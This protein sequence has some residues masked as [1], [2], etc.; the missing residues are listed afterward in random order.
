VRKGSRKVPPRGSGRPGRGRARDKA[1]GHEL[2]RIIGREDELEGGKARHKEAARADAMLLFNGTRRK[3]FESCFQR[4]CSSLNRL[5]DRVGVSP[6]TAKY[7]LDLLVRG[8]LLGEYRRGR[9]R[10]FFPRGLLE[11]G[12][13]ESTATIQD[14]RV[15]PVYELICGNP[16]TVQKDLTDRLGCSHQSVNRA[17]ARLAAEGLVRTVKE[18]RYTRYYP[19]ADPGA[20]ARS[21]RRRLKLF[22]ERFLNQLRSAGFATKVHRATADELV[23]SMEAGGEVVVVTLSR[24]SPFTGI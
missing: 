17:A 24:R 1:L 14:P 12:E 2:K 10:L 6:A 11:D 4:P 20:S 9:R 23:V 18:G 22:R 3:L 5:A 16:G 19:T 8:G 15:A 21:E 13:V 7:H